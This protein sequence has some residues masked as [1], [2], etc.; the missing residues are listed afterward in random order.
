MNRFVIFAFATAMAAGQTARVE[1]VVRAATGEPV[2]R[3]SVTLRRFSDPPPSPITAV[4]DDAGE[5]GFDGIAAGEHYVLTA[6]RVGYLRAI[7][8]PARDRPATLTLEAGQVLK[9]LVIEMAR[10]AVITGR[11]MD[12]AG[13]PMPGVTVRVVAGPEIYEQ[14]T[15]NDRGEYRIA[16]LPPGEYRIWASDPLAA[17]AEAG[18][19]VKL[20]TYHPGTTTEISAAKVLVREGAEARNIDI[21][22]QAGRAFT[23][24]GKVVDAATGAPV[25]G[26]LARIDPKEGATS[27]FTGRST[28][29]RTPTD[30]FTFHGV[31][32]GTYMIRTVRN[33]ISSTRPVP[34]L[35]GEVEV[36]VTD[37]DVMDVV[38][39]VSAGMTITGMIRLEGGDIQSLEPLPSVG[40]MPEN[41]DP[42][43]GEVRSSAGQDGSFA[44][45]NVPPGRLRWT[46]GNLPETMFVKSA[47]FRGA[48]V[49][50]SAIEAPLEGDGSLDIVVAEGAAVVTG[51]VRDA[52]GD[53]FAGGFVFLW[54]RTPNGRMTMSGGMQLARTDQNG[55]YHFQGLAPDDYY[56]AAFARP[57]ALDPLRD[58]SILARLKDSAASI[59]L[60]P[61]EHGVVDAPVIAAGQFEA[62]KAQL[63]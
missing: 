19:I 27:L 15:T 51:V 23:I 48:D 33:V 59:T 21:R 53:P 9:G 52:N 10:Q 12:A 11:V 18:A 57:P 42:G 5:F 2:A 37:Q 49:T 45:A 1:G 47:T 31:M 56:V 8:G 46:V 35:L 13:D 50:R 4:T 6:E 62:A 63:P 25:T 30:T 34:K 3:A 32:P 40:F 61:G 24:Q 38:L 55:A 26:V 43:S 39:R 22:M 54:P 36:L 28:S 7:S 16:S 44:V 60:G 17:T 41:I 29:G 58:Y 20:P 14:A